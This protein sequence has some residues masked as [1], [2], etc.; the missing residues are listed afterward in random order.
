MTTRHTGCEPQEQ[1]RQPGRGDAGADGETARPSRKVLLSG[2]PLG[3]LISLHPILVALTFIGFGWGTLLLI[4][5]RLEVIESDFLS[6]P[7]F[8]V[9]DL[10]L[11]P[12]CGALIA[13]YYRSA[14]LEM[15]TEW[16]T[17]IAVGSGTIAG[18]AAG[19]TAAFSIFA[20]ETYAGAW[21][22]P[23][24]LFI[25]FFA[26]AFISFLA[27]A[28]SDMIFYLSAR[29]MYHVAAVIVLPATHLTLKATLGGSLG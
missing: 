20:T 24:T 25:W 15:P 1:G 22:I 27:R 23:H 18:I 5:W 3:P 13:A 12:L 28:L 11:L 14:S 10:A 16:G 7:A 19:A 6:N 4:A 2:D 17:R 9:G 8:M 26:Y 21:S 29:K